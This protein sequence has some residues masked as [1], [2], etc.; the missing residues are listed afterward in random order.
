MKAALSSGMAPFLGN[1]LPENGL[2]VC[3]KRN[4]KSM[5]KMALNADLPIMEMKSSGFFNHPNALREVF[6]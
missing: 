1:F 3:P 5:Q 6:R 2:I 4:H